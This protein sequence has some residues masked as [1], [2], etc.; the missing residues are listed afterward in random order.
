MGADYSS[1]AVI[2]VKIDQGKLATSKMVKAFP[3][4]FGPDINFHPKTGKK[5]WMEK[6]EY[7]P[8]YDEYKG[9]LAGFRV[10]FTT[11]NTTMYCGIVASGTHSN[12][13][14]EAKRTKLED[15][16]EIK[17]KLK[18]ALEPLGLWDEKSFGLWTVLHCSY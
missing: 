5:L 7:I 12:C 8:Q 17:A 10:T 15:I 1:A 14:S 6:A 9:T 2:G 13:G 4:D 3:H 16:G 11:D 18:S